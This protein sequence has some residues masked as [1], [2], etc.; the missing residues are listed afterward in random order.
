MF[1]DH[2]HKIQEYE[3]S[4]PEMDE[5]KLEAGQKGQPVNPHE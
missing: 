1:D 3:Q 2:K 4:R 5:L